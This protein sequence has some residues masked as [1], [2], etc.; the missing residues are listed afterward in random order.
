MLF[1]FRFLASNEL[2]IAAPHQVQMKALINGKWPNQVRL[3][4]GGTTTPIEVT[5]VFSVFFILYSEG[6]SLAQKCDFQT[7]SS[8]RSLPYKSMLRFN[9]TLNCPKVAIQGLAV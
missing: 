9:P 7:A 8:L 6:S 5:L 3:V 1:V 2:D 4:S